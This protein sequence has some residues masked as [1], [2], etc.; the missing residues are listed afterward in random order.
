[1]IERVINPG[2]RFHAAGFF[3]MRPFDLLAFLLAIAYGATLSQIPTELYKDFGNYLVYAEHSWPRLQ[4]M[5]NQGVLTTLANE[6]V[7]LLIN[8]IMGSFLEPETVVRTI[9]FVSGSVVAWL[10]L[11]SRPKHFVWLVIFLL[12]PTVLKN[13]VIHLRQGAAIAVFVWA[14][15]SPNRVVRAILMAS[16]PFIH[17]SFFFIVAILWSARLMISARLGPEIRIALFVAL[18]VTLSFGLE[19]LAPGKHK[20]MNFQWQT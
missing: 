4:D 1:M 11:R 14:W 12:F 7:W 18:G 10:V 3:T 17:A 9:I 15:F 20:P 6:P 5:L 19:W 13:H 2:K 16:T 8:S